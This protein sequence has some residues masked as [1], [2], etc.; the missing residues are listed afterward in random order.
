MSF[1]GIV[2]RYS[3][4]MSMIQNGTITDPKEIAKLRSEAAGILAIPDQI[5]TSIESFSASQSIYKKY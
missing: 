1:T 2:D 5:R 3:D 4:I